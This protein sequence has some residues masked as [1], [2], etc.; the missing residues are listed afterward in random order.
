MSGRSAYVRKKI[1]EPNLTPARGRAKSSGSS[2]LSDI[3][4]ASVH[5]YPLPQGTGYGTTNARLLKFSESAREPEF[6]NFRHEVANFSNRSSGSQSGGS[7]SSRREAGALQN[8]GPMPDF[9][10]A[11]ARKPVLKTEDVS[12]IERSGFRSAVDK[13]SDEFRKGLT[14]AFTFGAKKKKGVDTRPPSAATIRPYNNLDN[15]SEFEMPSAPIQNMQSG[16][17]W[18]SEYQQVISPPPSAKLPP[19][20]PPSTT[21]PIKRWIGGGRPVQRWNKLRK[22]PEL[23]DPNGDVLVFLG[24]KG[25]SPRPNPSFRL[26]SHIIEAT[27]SRVLITLLREGSTEDDYDTQMHMPPSPVGAPP[28]IRHHGSHPHLNH[29]HGRTGQPTPPMS[30]EASLN[31]IDGQISYEMYF[32]TPPNMT[33]LDALRYAITTR[34]LFAL[35]YHASLVGLSLFQAL[36]DLLVRLDAYMPPEADNIGA[37]LNYLTARGIDDARNDPE[38]AVSVLAWSETPEVRWEEGWREAFLHCTGMYSRLE[39]CADF[40]NVTPIT[41]ALL[42]RACLETQLR[43]QAA[44][45]R[46]A[47]F[48]YGDIWPT[49]GPAAH[50]AARAAADRLQQFFT[51]HYVK[52]YGSWPPPET[53]ARTSDGEEMWL[54]RTT[55]KKMQKDFGALYDYL[56]NRDIVWDES[57]TRSSRK[58]MMVSESGDKSFDADT[59]DLP[60]TDMLIEFDNRMR[61]PHIP[62]PYPLVPESVPPVNS[63]GSGGNSRE[64]LRKDKNGKHGCDDRII[65]R[66]IQLAYTEATNIYTLG[67]D[68]T[69]SDLVESFVK[70]EKADQIGLVDP[71]CARR[72]RWVLI[73]GILQT[74]A[75]VSV[76][77]PNVR[78]KD[79]VAYHLSPRL[80]GT[81]TPPWKGISAPAPE[82]C[83]QLSH[84]WLAPRTWSSNVEGVESDASVNSNGADPVLRMLRGQAQKFP[85]P[86]K[87]ATSRPGNPSWQTASSRS[88]RSSGL[89]APPTPTIWGG[90]STRSVSAYS[91][92]TASSVRTPT[93]AHFPS[94]R[95]HK[96]PRSRGGDDGTKSERSLATFGHSAGRVDD[97]NWPPRSY[98]RRL[99]APVPLDLSQ[100]VTGFGDFLGIN[101]EPPSPDPRDEPLP[102][103]SAGHSDVLGPLIRDFDELDSVIEEHGFEKD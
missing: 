35:L 40:K 55:A 62:H 54:T 52:A 84:C 87:I 46:L 74:L 18:D 59:A 89:A 1:T 29:H 76:D 67:S 41:R 6:A 82:A 7:D 45:E 43:V 63:P 53:G 71:F 5:D 9:A 80:K 2:R 58:W 68:F 57:E 90:S 14:K 33:K 50:G 60:L 31:D 11:R 20:P 86:P 10:Y 94:Q 103:M 101:Q 23:W 48:A 37:I 26:S 69:Q 65:E 25:Q 93:S 56:V 51:S 28:M 12:G 16:G 91:D 85:R 98:S 72:G 102:I 42:E 17:M 15:A 8:H 88:A 73:Y 36:S 49:S 100:D 78:Y 19:I 97:V 81:K 34:N 96:N 92:D 66:R 70:F 79:G 64:R 13:K 30:E 83:H 38:I 4:D 3:D 61:F 99:P 75:S 95:S 47:E 44:E 39:D 32:P 21:P 22:D 77:S 24:R 27:E